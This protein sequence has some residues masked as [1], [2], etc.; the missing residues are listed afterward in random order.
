[1]VNHTQTTKEGNVNGHVVLGDCVHGRR[2]K[3]SLERDALRDGGVEGDFG[4]GEA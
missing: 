3:G 2:D 1:V 4:G